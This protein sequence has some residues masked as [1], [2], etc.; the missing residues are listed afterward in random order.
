VRS[1]REKLS[2]ARFSE[3]EAPTIGHRPTLP[4][5]DS[6]PEGSK[7]GSVSTARWRSGEARGTCEVGRPRPCL[8]GRHGA[9]SPGLVGDRKSGVAPR[10]TVAHVSSTLRVAQRSLRL[11]RDSQGAIVRPPPGP[12]TTPEGT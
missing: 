9:R 8:T 11:G 1:E 6:E 10:A 5:L 4:A 2:G 7:R 3:T 12:R